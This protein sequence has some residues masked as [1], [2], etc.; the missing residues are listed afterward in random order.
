LAFKDKLRL[1]RRAKFSTL[2]AGGHVVTLIH[3]T[4]QLIFLFPCR[5]AADDVFW[6]DDEDLKTTLK[7]LFSSSLTITLNKLGWV[8]LAL[9]IRLVKGQHIRLEALKASC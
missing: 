1:T 2:D 7:T 5:L 4:A 8:S 3:K 6:L 9:H